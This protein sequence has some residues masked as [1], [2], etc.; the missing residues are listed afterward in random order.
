MS[1]G[2]TSRLR[3]RSEQLTF[4]L[5]FA[6]LGVGFMPSRTARWSIA[7]SPTGAVMPSVVSWP[8]SFHH[9]PDTSNT[10]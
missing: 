10:R 5:S 8:K 6:N 9:L 4:G 7:E 3:A 2:Y 1:T